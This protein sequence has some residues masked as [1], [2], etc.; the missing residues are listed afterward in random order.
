MVSK[1]AAVRFVVSHPLC[2]LLNKFGKTQS[3]LL[4]S[5]LVDFYSPEDLSSAKKQ[6]LKD[7]GEIQSVS[8]P[9]V[10]QQRQGDNRA[11]RDV[12]DMFTLLTTLDEAENVTL[13]ALPTYV[14][15][16]PDNIPSIRL[17][18]GDFGIFMTMLEKL[19][20]KLN[21]MES[22]IC[23]VAKDVNTIRSKVSSLEPGV[24][25][26]LQWPPVSSQ[27]V[28]CDVNKSKSQPATG[29]SASGT[30]NQSVEP[31]TPGISDQTSTMVKTTADHQSQTYEPST[32]STQWASLVS[33][34][35]LHSNRFDVL[36]TTDDE[37]TL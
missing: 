9:H 18:E 13:S 25:S 1:I 8:F 34:P 28:Q 7:I 4:K 10:P 17:Y 16:N 19:E 15:D 12:D 30:N 32:Q 29:L 3:K 6:L 35:L 23:T 37:R 2:F 22:A 11:V 36:A 5:A 27:P 14:S 31:M 33:T 21:M 26:L 24:Q 20:A